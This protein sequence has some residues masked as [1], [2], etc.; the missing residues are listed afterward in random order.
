MHTCTEKGLRS[1]PLKNKRFV[2]NPSL[3]TKRSFDLSLK[4][5]RYFDLSLKTKRSYDLSLKTKRPTK[6]FP[7]N[8]RIVQLSMEMCN[9]HEN[10]IKHTQNLNY[11]W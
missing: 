8:I 1:L 7:L 11:I 2:V 4:T 6:A 10:R 3:K 9:K 5:K